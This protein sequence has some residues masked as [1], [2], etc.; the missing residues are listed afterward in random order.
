MHCNFIVVTVL[1]SIHWLRFYN[2]M[3]LLAL[4]TSSYFKHTIM[5][6]RK[7]QFPTD[8]YV[9]LF[10]STTRM[11]YRLEGDDAWEKNGNDKEHKEEENKEKNK[12][13]SRCLK[14]RDNGVLLTAISDTSHI[15]E[16]S[17]N[18]I[19]LKKTPFCWVQYIVPICES[20]FKTI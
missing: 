3:W 10:S 16:I 17:L 14:F 5:R 11:H 15:S 2:L 18:F 20:H 8:V 4:L 9:I 13:N 19:I 6:D 1:Y 12:T 7:S